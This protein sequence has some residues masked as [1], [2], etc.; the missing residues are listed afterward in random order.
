MSIITST[1]TPERIVICGSPMS[2]EP[3]LSKL[4]ISLTPE[5]TVDYE[6]PV[7]S[8]IG[9]RL[10]LDVDTADVYFVFKSGERV[11]AHKIHLIASSDVFKT[12]FNGAWKDQNEVKIVDTSVVGFKEFLQFFYYN[13]V[14]LSVT[15]IGEVIN[16][17]E[18]Y[19]ISG[20]LDICWSFLKQNITND[21]VCELY[22]LTI[23]YE[24]FELKD[25]CQN[26]INSKTSEIFET[27]GFLKCHRR[28]LSRILKLG[29]L[30]IPE[31]S[32]FKAVMSW[33]KCTSGEEELTRNALQTHLGELFFDIR[34]RSMNL[35]EFVSL[36]PEYG[37]LF[38]AHEFNEILQ[39]I[40]YNRFQP[41]IFN[42]LRRTSY[43][44]ISFNKTI[45]SN[46]T[47]SA[48]N[49]NSIIFDQ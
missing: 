32:V 37:N 33:V 5:A 22:D 39:M 26:R 25:I 24:H 13:K 8:T 6:S 23:F 43:T 27:S 35:N 4:S 1:S 3:E 14:I 20:C 28:V 48:L 46:F 7:L 16:L 34:F 38:T 19:N 2:I 31:K 40:Q 15:N 49:A 10:Y 11:P 44:A 30:S 47:F 45:D 18:M 17:G 29:N 12:M 41:K 42:A 9:R 36:L 21:N